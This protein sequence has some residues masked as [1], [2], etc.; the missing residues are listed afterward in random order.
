MGKLNTN[1]LWDTLGIL[2]AEQFY[3]QEPEFIA[4]SLILYLNANLATINIGV[5]DDTIGVEEI[6]GFSDN[7]VM[8]I[9]AVLY[10]RAG[11]PINYDLGPG[12]MLAIDQTAPVITVTSPMDFSAG[13]TAAVA[14]SLSEN[15]ASG[16]VTWT[17]ISGAE[18]PGS[19][20][21]QNLVGDELL[22]EGISD[23]LS[24]NPVLVHGALYNIT[25]DATE[26]PGNTVTPVTINSFT[27]DT[28]SPTFS[29]LSPDSL[30]FINDSR[31]S[32]Q[33]NES[34]KSG[35][36]KWTQISGVPEDSSV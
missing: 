10:D 22:T 4:D 20:H 11:N 7:R 13:N 36:V 23:T 34:L 6:T 15:I 21:I 18:D 3:L 29:S 16:M 8:E 14:Y 31:V 27:F 9:K 17:R 24:D 1:T 2:G 19:P 26:V 33:I 25:F 35:Q 12:A 5:E 32:Y 30:D 28:Q